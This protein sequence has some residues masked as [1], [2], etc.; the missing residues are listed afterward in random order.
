MT[1]YLLSIWEIPI[2]SESREY[3]LLRNS[4]ERKRDD[5]EVLRLKKK[6]RRRKPVSG[7][8]SS[9]SR[10]AEPPLNARRDGKKSAG[11]R[12]GGGASA[13]SHASTSFCPRCETPVNPPRV[14]L[15]TGWRSFFR[16]LGP[17]PKA[18]AAEGKSG[19]R[20]FD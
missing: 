4:Q 15:E 13:R 11:V 20:L 7:D 14:C 8:I 1:S 18:G 3:A 16:R 6:R 9:R 10:L 5:R 19:G 2:E 17:L 12:G